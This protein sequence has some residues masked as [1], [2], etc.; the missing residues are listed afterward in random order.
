[1]LWKKTGSEKRVEKEKENEEEKKEEEKEEEKEE[2]SL[3]NEAKARMDQNQGTK[4]SQNPNS[5]GKYDA[6]L[7]DTNNGNVNL[8]LNQG[9]T[10]GKVLSDKFGTVNNATF[11]GVNSNG[12]AI[13]NS[14]KT[15][16]FVGCVYCSYQYGYIK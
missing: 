7:Y 4:I 15:G 12:A 11:Q 2:N 5:P 8:T 9:Q 1:M 16:N 6:K 3:G 13:F 10:Y 14:P